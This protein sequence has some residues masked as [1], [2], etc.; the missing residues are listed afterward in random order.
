MY[1]YVIIK[2]LLNLQF[3]MLA[4][5]WKYSSQFFIQSKSQIKTGQPV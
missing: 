5:T 2:G 3:P 4:Y 1:K